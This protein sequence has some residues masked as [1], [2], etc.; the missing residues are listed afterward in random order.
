VT[1]CAFVDG[2][3]RVDKVVKKSRSFS[4]WDTVMPSASETIIPR[5]VALKIIARHRQFYGVNIKTPHRLR[6][7]FLNRLKLLKDLP[8]YLV[9][10]WCGTNPRALWELNPGVA[11]SSGVLP[12]PDRKS[13]LGFPL[14]VPRGMGARVKKELGRNGYISG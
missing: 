4:Y 11:V 14:R 2:T 8:L 9:A 3:D 6:Y 10:R 13:P 5:L 1:I 12:K 7:D